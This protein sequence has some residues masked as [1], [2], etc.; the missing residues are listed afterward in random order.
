MEELKVI[1]TMK[2]N[3]QNVLYAE[4]LNDDKSNISAQKVVLI[5]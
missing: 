1:H 5:L 4:K 2:Q 3:I